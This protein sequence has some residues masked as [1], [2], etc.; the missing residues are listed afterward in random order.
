M[1][2]SYAPGIVTVD[3]VGPSRWIVVLQGEHDMTNS[4]LLRTELAT[5]FA[6]GT[7]VIV[8]LSGATFI[9][10][11]T[12]KELI[13][14]QE[15]IHEIPTEQLAIVAPK[16]GFA[17]RVLDLLHTDHVLRIFQNRDD[18]LRLLDTPQAGGEDG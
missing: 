9:D 4:D 12:V 10:S 18:A 8:D 15:R 1:S 17:R 5:I 3:R 2:S 13:A 11:S 14:V 6:Q 7:A 16:D